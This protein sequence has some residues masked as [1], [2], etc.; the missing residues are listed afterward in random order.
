MANVFTGDISRQCSKDGVWFLPLYNCV[1]PAVTSIQQR[2]SM[3]VNSSVTYG[4]YF[5]SVTRSMLGKILSRRYI[6]IVFYV[7]QK[8]K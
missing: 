8:I 1:R 3:H 6:E 7:P 4:S 5:F 2:V